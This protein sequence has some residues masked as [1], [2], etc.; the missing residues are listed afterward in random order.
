MFGRFPN[1]LNLEYTMLRCVVVE[2]CHQN[3]LDLCFFLFGTRQQSVR[4]VLM[5]MMLIVRLRPP[6]IL[7]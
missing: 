5:E 2:N 6:N 4:M 7:K 3:T 1:E